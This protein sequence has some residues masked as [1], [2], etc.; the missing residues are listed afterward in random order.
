[1]QKCFTDQLGNRISIDFPPKRIISIVPSQTELLFDLGLNEEILGVTKFCIHPK[2]KC[3]STTKI[4]GTKKLNLPLIEKLQPD[5]IIGNKEENNIDDVLYLHKRYPV[6]M[7]DVYDIDGA[8]KTIAD[9]G[10]LVNKMPEAEYLNHLI[11]AGFRDL[12]L[13]AAQHGIKKRVVYFIWQ[14]PYM[15]AGKN[16][17]IDSILTT[18]GLK[19]VI[20]ERRYPEISLTDLKALNCDLLLLS[21]EPFPFRRKHIAKIKEYLPNVEVMLV[22]GEMFSWYGSRMVKA[23]EYFFNFQKRLV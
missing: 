1:M 14:K 10:D 17:F 2:E 18:I 13:L 22:D 20:A 8:K 16:T 21:S 23:I 9:I 7:S 15:A 4:G 12:K 6:W 19:N 5:L 11:D 3:A